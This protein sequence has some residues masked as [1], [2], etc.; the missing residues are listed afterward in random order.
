MMLLLFEKLYSRSAQEFEKLTDDFCI[1]GH[2]L[3]ILEISRV[4]SFL[5]IFT[6]QEDY[7]ARLFFCSDE[8]KADTEKI[9]LQATMSF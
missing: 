4:D 3:E 1:R 8:F 5:P 9:W 7:L 6:S 2:I